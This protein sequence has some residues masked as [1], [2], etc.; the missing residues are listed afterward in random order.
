MTI[1]IFVTQT[2]TLMLSIHSLPSNS[3][4]THRAPMTYPFWGGASISSV[5][6]FAPFLVS[7]S[8]ILGVMYDLHVILYF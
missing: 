5:T 4:A 6:V 3:P 2:S 1:Y 7:L 8:A